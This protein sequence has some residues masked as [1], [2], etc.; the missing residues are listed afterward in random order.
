MTHMAFIDLVMVIMQVPVSYDP[1]N[2]IFIWIIATA[3]INFSLARVRLL[4]KGG[5]YSRA[6]FINFGQIPH[7]TIH[8]NDTMNKVLP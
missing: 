2:T 1:A 5:S 8:K 3:A 4:I 6:A 7:D